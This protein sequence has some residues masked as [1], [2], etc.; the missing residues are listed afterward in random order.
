V[1]MVLWHSGFKLLTKKA[2]MLLTNVSSTPLAL[3]Q[4]L[5]P[6]SSPVL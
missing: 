3:V 1:A 4:R 6:T 2:S 5:F